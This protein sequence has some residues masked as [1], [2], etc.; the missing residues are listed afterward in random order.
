MLVV[1]DLSGTVDTEAELARSQRQTEMILRAA[2]EGVVGTDTDGR[3]VLVNPAAAQILGYRAGELGGR[4]LHTLV[5]HSRADGSAFPYAESRSPTP[6]GPAASTACAARS[7]TP[8]AATKR[9]VEPQPAAAGARSRATSCRRGTV[10]TGPCRARAGRPPHARG[11]TATRTARRV[12]SGRRGRC[13]C[14]ALPARRDAAYGSRPRRAPAPRH[15]SVRTRRT[16]AAG[17]HAEPAAPGLQPVGPQP[18]AAQPVPPNQ[19]GAAA[20]PQAAGPDLQPVGSNAQPVPPNAPAAGPAPQPAAPGLQPV[21]PHAQAPQPVPPNQQ[22]PQAPQPADAAAAQ[23]VQPV[24][25][26]AA[27][28]R[29]ARPG[30][31][32]RRVSRPPTPGSTTPCRWTSPR[33]TP[34]RSRTPPVRPRVAVGVAVAPPSEAAQA[35]GARLVAEVGVDE[36]LVGLRLGR[37]AV[38]AGTGDAVAGE[39]GDRRLEDPGLGGLGVP[40]CHGD[41]GSATCNQPFG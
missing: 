18:Q 39:L 36:L 35:P 10:R 28:G 27:G 17:Q 16:P 4:E 41:R 11:R 31:A 1:R 29:A 32:P 14:A 23:A 37:D 6:C 34:R 21:G 7:S 24:G 2:S 13:W 33:T 19:Q 5:L 26:V 25:P 8:G 15:R 22:A 12:G 30:P 20:T 40:D 3:I 9:P 38:D